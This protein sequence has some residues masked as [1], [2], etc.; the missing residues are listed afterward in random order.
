MKG[1]CDSQ[2]SFL[3]EVHYRGIIEV[4]VI[5]NQKVINV[6]TTLK[7][8]HVSIL[9][10]KRKRLVNN[11]AQSVPIGLPTQCLFLK[12]YLYPTCKKQ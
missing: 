4:G 5:Q 9:I 7:A 10:K 12:Y 6:A 3:A 11:G 8:S 2:W 1:Q